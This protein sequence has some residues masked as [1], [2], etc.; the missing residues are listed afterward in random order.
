MRFGALLLL[1]ASA[2]LSAFAQQRSAEPER[3]C[4]AAPCYAEHNAY[5]AQPVTRYAHGVLGD[6][7]EWGTLILDGA[8]HVLSPSSVFE[9][10][11]PRLADIDG[12]GAPEAVVIESHASKGAQLAIYRRDGA[13][14]VKHASTPYIGTRFRWLAPAGIADFDG[15]GTLDFAYV[16]RPHLAKTLRIWSYENGRL[17][18]IAAIGGL[19]NHR[20]G[21]DFISGGLRVC[22]GEPEIVTADQGWSRVIGTRFLD[23]QWVSRVLARNTGTSA[24]ARAMRC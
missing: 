19:T 12:D 23:G 17:R 1:L 6:A 9:D 16:D 15:N 11:K 18:E 5:F 3:F 14:L 21:E 7:V 20:I 13:R 22:N 24:F 8:K 4:A 2:P 10:L